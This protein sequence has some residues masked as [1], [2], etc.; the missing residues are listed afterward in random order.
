MGLPGGVNLRVLVYS[1][2]APRNLDISGSPT[3]LLTE[4]KQRAEPAAAV[5]EEEKEEE[6]DEDTKEEAS[7]RA[8]QDLRLCKKADLA[9]LATA[10]E[11]RCIFVKL[12]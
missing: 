3:S 12:L 7:W 5:V 1:D 11:R 4:E 8:C 2:L 10:A 6:G 9:C